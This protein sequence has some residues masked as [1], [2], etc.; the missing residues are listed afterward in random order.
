MSS[1][2]G[3]LGEQGFVSTTYS[4]Q[5]LFGNRWSGG[6]PESKYKNGDGLSCYAMLRGELLFGRKDHILTNNN[7]YGVVGAAPLIARTSWNGIVH[8]RV[9]ED[10]LASRYAFLGINRSEI[11]SDVEPVSGVTGQ[12]SGTGTIFNTGDKVIKPFDWITW[13]PPNIAN[14]PNQTPNL[15]DDVPVEKLLTV[16]EPLKETTI[17]DIIHKNI[18]ALRKLQHEGG[19]LDVPLNDKTDNAYDAASMALKKA[20]VNIMTESVIHLESKGYIRIMSPSLK[21]LDEAV[22]KFYQENNADYPKNI[23][24]IINDHAND[25]WKADN[26]SFTQARLAELFDDN[27]ATKTSIIDITR[28]SNTLFS[29]LMTQG[30]AHVEII[31]DLF[32]VKHENTAANL[33]D[34]FQ[35][36]F[37]SISTITDRIIGYALNYAKPGQPVDIL[38]GRFHF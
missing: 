24:E 5:N 34:L 35:A 28:E 29:S 9:S 33:V 14:G 8:N 10:E 18:D 15:P 38:L 26:G 22:Y 30:E 20:I 1:S 27:A 23:Q 4:Y 21:L 12:I 36:W 19:I 17:Q 31:K 16:V 3:K 6:N 7:Y 37:N 25:D 32:D 11:R 2:S 13:R